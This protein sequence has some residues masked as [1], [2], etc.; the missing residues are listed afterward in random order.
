MKPNPYHFKEVTDNKN[1]ES[2]ERPDSFCPEET[3]HLKI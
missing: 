2:P 3:E 1:E